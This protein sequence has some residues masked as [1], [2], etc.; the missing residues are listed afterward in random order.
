MSGEN[1]V[2]VKTRAACGYVF[3]RGA[4]KGATCTRGCVPGGKF[5]TIHVS[6][7]LDVQMFPTE[8]MRCIVASVR[9]N[10]AK[11]T[12][13]RLCSLGGTCKEYREIVADQC[14]TLYEGLVGGVGGGLDP[15][16]D[17]VLAA[18]GMS[19]KRRLHLLLESGCMRCGAPRITKVHWP[20][21]IRACKGCMVA[22]TVPDYVLRNRYKLTD[23]EGARWIECLWWKRYIGEASYRSYLVSD[24]ERD[25]GMTLGELEAS[26]EARSA[27][28][29]GRI[30]DS[31]GVSVD[32]LKRVCQLCRNSFPDPAT[33]A[34]LFYRT[35]ARTFL[36]ERGYERQFFVAEYDASYTVASAETYDAFLKML[37]DDAE[38]LEEQVRRQEYAR[39]FARVEKELNVI[40]HT[41]PYFNNTGTRTAVP[42]LYTRGPEDT[43]EAL[44][45]AVPDLEASVRAF[46]EAN[47][48]VLPFK[49]P[50]ALRIARMLIRYPAREARVGVFLSNWNANMNIERSERVDIHTWA[51]LVD[52]IQAFEAME[53]LVE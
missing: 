6:R 36:L 50:T 18:E 27:A 35:R 15:A 48:L 31:L 23:Y 21:P 1:Q 45:Q 16:N 39:E 40:L 3:R 12:F 25:V 33:T 7:V 4:S 42:E 22:L 13:A 10:T 26:I 41:K 17:R 30:A 29:I 47:Q 49:H 9:D 38:R 14:K 34:A 5:C 37:E 52:M 46:M 32:E 11:Q 53:D 19:Y 51:D 2:V 43:I 28:H 20:F 8:I 44:A 24:V